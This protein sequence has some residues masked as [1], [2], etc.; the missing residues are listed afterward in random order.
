MQYTDFMPSVWYHRTVEV[1][2]DWNGNRIF[3]HFGAVDYDCRA[4]VNGKLVG[5]HYGGSSSFSFEIT[6]VLKEGKN[7]LVVCAVDEVRSRRNQQANRVS[8]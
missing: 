2:D 3:L 1:P 5:R 8:G 4:W 7:G 6:D